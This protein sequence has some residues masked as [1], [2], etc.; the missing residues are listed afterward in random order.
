MSACLFSCIGLGPM[1]FWPRRTICGSGADAL[2]TLG[3]AGGGVL[4]AHARAQSALGNGVA[5]RLG[6]SQFG[7]PFSTFQPGS[8]ARFGGAFV[9]MSTI[10]IGICIKSLGLPLKTACRRFRNLACR[11]LS[12]RQPAI[13]PGATCPIPDG[14]SCVISCAHIKP[15][16]PGLSFALRAGYPGKPGSGTSITFVR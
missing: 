14:A 15:H 8:K 5:A 12:W 4:P 11:E 7:P 6:I 9:R 10:K 1:K 2:P 16:G 13:W 3:R